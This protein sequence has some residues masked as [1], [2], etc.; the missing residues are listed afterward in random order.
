MFPPKDQW[1][2][3]KQ[4]TPADKTKRKAGQKR[5]KNWRVLITY[6]GEPNRFWEK[7]TQTGCHN[8]SRL[9]NQ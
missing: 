7:K 8:I 6:F 9:G 3:P 1:K 2:E 5:A 4:L